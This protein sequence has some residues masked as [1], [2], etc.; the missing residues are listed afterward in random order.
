MTRQTGLLLDDVFL[1]HT[2]GKRHPE[3]PERL[4][5]I[6]N[7]L[8]SSGLDAAC[9]ALPTR[10]AT[11]DEIGAIHTEAYLKR[12]QEACAS[13][14]GYIDTPDSTICQESYSIA[15]LAAGSVLEAADAVM[16][17][18]IKNAF[19]AVR[20][21]GHHCE[22]AES[23]GFC[24]LANAAIAGLYL[25]DQHGLDRVAIVDWDVHHGN[26]TQHVFAQSADIL[27]C[28]IH[29]HPDYVYP[30][31]GYAHERGS[32]AG[33]GATLNVPLMPGSG[34]DCYMRAFE[35]V[36][37]P[38]LEDFRPQFIIISAGFDAHERDPLAPLNLQTESF[39]WMTDRITELAASVANGRVVSVLE[40]GYDLQALSD[41]VCQHV[42][43]LTT[44]E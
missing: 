15:K 10:E 37:L 6:R 38:S 43:K 30:G 13:G 1:G 4:T 21:P 8:A 36:L 27:S 40:G 32:G 3:R 31:T 39:G 34:D 42:M 33:K 44:A 7:G 29:G 2:T 24:L 25:I 28:S 18:S 5:A 35:E 22:R 17:G 16:K 9:L 14:A 11:D 41:S 12:L 19:C 23:M 20:P 26:G